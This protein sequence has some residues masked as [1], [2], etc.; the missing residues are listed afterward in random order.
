M[1]FGTLPV[2]TK[3]VERKRK[4]NE[5][6]PEEFKMNS[7]FLQFRITGSVKNQK[8]RRTQMQFNFGQPQASSKTKFEDKSKYLPTKQYQT[9]KSPK[10]RFL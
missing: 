4:I 3:L 2:R 8:P 9:E 5:E 1:N 6:K 7:T 10:L